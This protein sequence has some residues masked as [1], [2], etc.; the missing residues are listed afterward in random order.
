V[1]KFKQAISKN[2]NSKV[3]KKGFSE[4]ASSPILLQAR[5]DKIWYRNIKIKRTLN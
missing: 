2:E 3:F 1:N 5:G 4:A